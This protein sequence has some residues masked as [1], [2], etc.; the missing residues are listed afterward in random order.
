[1][2]DI[3]QKFYYSNYYGA[4]VNNYGV[5]CGILL[6]FWGNKGW[7]L[8]TGQVEEQKIMKDKL[9]DRKKLQVGLEVNEQ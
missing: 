1:M 4:S 3:D 6:R 2:K 9:I 8:D 5:K 7:I